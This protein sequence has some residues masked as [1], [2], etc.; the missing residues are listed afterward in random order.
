MAAKTVLIVDDD[1][2]Q[3]I[4]AGLYLEHAG[5]AVLHARDGREGYELARAARPSLVLM[6]F[7]MPELDGISSFRMIAADAETRQIPVV[8]VT[9][10]VL[11]WPE[12]RS[13]RE[14]FAGHISKPC[15]LARIRD[16]VRR[17]I[18]PAE[19][20]SLP[21]RTAFAAVAPQAMAFG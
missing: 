13:L 9:A 20:P 19:E 17:V 18:G 3:H 11:A 7:R 2:D 5:Y 21:P 4:L 1:P 14:G 8:A 15:D 16:V 12:S 10:D 6:D